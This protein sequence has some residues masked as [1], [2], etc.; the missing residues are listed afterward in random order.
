M[1]QNVAAPKG[2]IGP[3]ITMLALGVPAA[4]Q[5]IILYFSLKVI[6]SAKETL[7]L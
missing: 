2:Y 3:P 6:S 4:A 1:T 7:S 5:E